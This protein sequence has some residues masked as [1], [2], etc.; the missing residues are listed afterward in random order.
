M[1]EVVLVK[2]DNSGMWIMPDS[3]KT[4]KIEKVFMNGEEI[5][6]GIDYIVVDEDILD[7]LHVTE[8]SFVTAKMRDE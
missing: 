1:K 6:E 5:F 2:L 7:V 4:N 8:Y 3:Y